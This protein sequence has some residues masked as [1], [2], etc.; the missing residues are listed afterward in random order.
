LLKVSVVS[1]Y[2]LT[3]PTNSTYQEKTTIDALQKQKITSQMT[4]HVQK[5][6]N[7]EAENCPSQGSQRLQRSNEEKKIE[8][9]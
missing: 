8:D 9:C 2:T 5:S 4:V 3:T 1:A 7:R 6:Y